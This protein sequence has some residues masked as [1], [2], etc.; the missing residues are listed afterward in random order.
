MTTDTY[1]R[2]IITAPRDTVLTII[3]GV[4]DALASDDTARA[5]YTLNLLRKIITSKI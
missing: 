5:L 3:D 1:G 4:A 2:A